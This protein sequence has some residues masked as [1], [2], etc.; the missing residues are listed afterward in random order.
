MTKKQPIERVLIAEDDPDVRA[1]L[2][3]MFQH[4]GA[5]IH[6]SDNCDEV[7]DEVKRFRPDLAVLDIMMPSRWGLDGFEVCRLLRE[8]LGSRCPKI[9][10]YSA[11]LDGVKTDPETL[12]AE[13]G[14]D[15][16]LLKPT[17]PSIMWARILELWE[18][19]SDPA[20]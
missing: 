13:V 17:D 4:K 2:Q 8:K 1:T 12:R 11:I 10:I 7:L 15:L 6:T 19:K 18:P 9:V 14:A 3:V 20:C 5:L 16:F